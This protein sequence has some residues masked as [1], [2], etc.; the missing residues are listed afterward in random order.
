[1]NTNSKRKEYVEMQRRHQEEINNFPIS[2][3]FSKDQVYGALKKIGA[4]SLKECVTVFGTG[5][6]VKK[7]DKTDLVNML[8]GFTE[9]LH[10]KMKNDKE[11]AEAAF[12]YEMDNHEYVINLDGDEDV[13]DSLVLTR[14]ELKEFGLE[15]AYQN[16]RRKHMKRAGE[17]WGII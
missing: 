4:S 14:E 17:E 1:M 2:F 5:D 13:L 3:A 10:E 11:F 8:I 15:E 12:E 9:E 6:I 16:A 7:K